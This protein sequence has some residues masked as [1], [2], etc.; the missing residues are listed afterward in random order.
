MK[1]L[2]TLEEAAMFGLSIL[3]FQHTNLEWWW[4]LALILAPD[5]GMI[6]YVIN[7]RIGMITYNLFHHKAI[8]VA[9]IFLGMQLV[10]EWVYFSGLILLGHASMDRVFG[11]GLKFADSFF[12]THLGWIQPPKNGSPQ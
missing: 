3:L 12:H 7:P 8:A 11:Y 2:L 9:V 6:G 10:N 5:I 4:Y 1:T